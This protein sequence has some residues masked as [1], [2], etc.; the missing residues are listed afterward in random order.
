MTSSEALKRAEALRD[1]IFISYCSAQHFVETDHSVKL[2]RNGD[3]VKWVANEIYLAAQSHR[4][5]DGVE[6]CTDA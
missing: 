5:R 4:N 3:W 2:P 1:E 6:E